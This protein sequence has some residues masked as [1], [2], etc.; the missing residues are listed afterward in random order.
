MRKWHGGK[1]KR[2]KENQDYLRAEKFG[3]TKPKPKWFQ[4]PLWLFQ[5][6]H[7]HVIF[8]M[9]PF[10]SCHSFSCKLDTNLRSPGKTKV[11]RSDWNVTTSAKYFLNCRLRAVPSLGGWAGLCK[12]TSWARRGRKSAKQGSFLDSASV[13]AFRFLLWDP[14]LASLDDR[15][16]SVRQI[17][18]VLWVRGLLP[19]QKAEFALL[20]PMDA[21]KIH[22]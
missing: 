20:C 2:K 8:S 11:P 3:K 4:T 17:N 22:C 21:Y 19:Q 15:L 7:K 14:F 13:P 12:K 9:V 6:S 1:E 18:P 10:V 5:A 16:Y